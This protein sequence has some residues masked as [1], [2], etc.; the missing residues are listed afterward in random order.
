MFGPKWPR[1]EIRAKMWLGQALALQIWC[2]PGS[3]GR[4][5]W[6]EQQATFHN[7][8]MDSPQKVLVEN[9]VSHGYLFS[10]CCCNE[11]SHSFW[12]KGKCSAIHLAS[13][14]FGIITT[15]TRTRG[16]KGLEHPRSHLAS[17]M[18][19]DDTSFYRQFGTT[20]IF[21]SSSNHSHRSSSRMW[22]LY[23]DQTLQHF[24]G[25]CV[26]SY[27]GDKESKEGEERKKIKLEVREATS[28]KNSSPP[29]KML[30]QNTCTGRSSLLT[31]NQK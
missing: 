16:W 5:G 6:N 18:L 24:D 1:E 31:Y 2:L 29:K 19:W 4:L 27:L 14:F 30:Y 9:T 26:C 10:L 12:A 23:R 20:D 21:V 28:L 7:I 25:I 13:I 11:A 22:A 17:S 3:G 15:C 8:A